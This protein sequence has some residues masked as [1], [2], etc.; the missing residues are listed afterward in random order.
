MKK[1]ICLALILLLLN[2]FDG[3]GTYYLVVNNITTE[4]NPILKDL[5]NFDPSFFLMIKVYFISFLI[6]FLYKASLQYKLA[7]RGIVLLIGVYLIP[8]FCNGY[9]LVDSFQR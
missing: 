8:L 6:Y 3:F 5:L 1:K 2:L 7:E 9:I 4:A